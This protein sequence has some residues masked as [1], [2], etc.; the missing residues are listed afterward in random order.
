MTIDLASWKSSWNRSVLRWS[1]DW[2]VD[3]AIDWTL[4]AGTDDECRVLL[5][6][7]NGFAQMSTE[8]QKL[9]TCTNL[10]PTHSVCV[11]VAFGSC[12][13]VCNSPVFMARILKRESQFFRSKKVLLKFIAM[14]TT[15]NRKFRCDPEIWLPASA[16]ADK[17]NQN[18]NWT[19]SPFGN[20]AFR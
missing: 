18:G 12:V 2:T 19:S 5:W 20:S 4:S 13:A 15:E 17:N 8:F 10:K 1:V 11:D 7:S 16:V 6:I 3:W 14:V 9:T